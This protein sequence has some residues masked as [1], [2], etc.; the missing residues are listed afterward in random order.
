MSIIPP[1]HCCR[2]ARW[3]PLRLPR[4]WGNL[5]TPHQGDRVDSGKLV[6]QS[7]SRMAYIVAAQARL[8][9]LARSVGVLQWIACSNDNH[10]L[11]TLSRGK[12]ERVV[13]L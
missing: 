10:C 5:T 8:T 4:H 11:L 6:N 9:V 7:H 13:A 1:F 2:F 3:V 12:A